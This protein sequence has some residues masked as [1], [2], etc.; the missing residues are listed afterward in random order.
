M[1]RKHSDAAPSRTTEGESM[2]AYWWALKCL[3]K[4]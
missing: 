2:L 1:A 3:I 4:S